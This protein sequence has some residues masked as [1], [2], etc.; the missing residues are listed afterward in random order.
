RRPSASWL[1]LP[2]DLAGLACLAA[3]LL[4]GVPDALALVRLGLAGRADLRRHLADELLVDA[5]DREAGGVLEL[6]AD[7]GRRVDLDRVAVAEREDELVARLLRA[8]P[9]T[10]DLEALAVPVGDADDH[11]VDERPGQAVETL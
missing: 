9:D 6:E 2:A 8:V 5:H 7:A 4:A 1:L 10:D 3:D 11:V